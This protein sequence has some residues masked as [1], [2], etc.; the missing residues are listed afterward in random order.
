MKVI[1]Y[2]FLAFVGLLMISVNMGWNLFNSDVIRMIK[3]NDKIG[4]FFLMGGVAF[5]TNII[6]DLRRVDIKGWSVLM[7]SAI[8]FV[9][10][11]IEECSQAFLVRRNFEVLDMVCN[12]SG[13]LVFQWLAGKVKRYL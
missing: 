3:F 13:I 2:C 8:V 6:F 10:C 5:F 12:Y 1:G 9:F 4:H 7:G 11:T